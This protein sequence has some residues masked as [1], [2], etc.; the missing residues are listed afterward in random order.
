MAEPLFLDTAYL[1]ALL[2]TGDQWHSAALHWRDEAI[3]RI[4]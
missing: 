1:V 2:H 3:V 4:F